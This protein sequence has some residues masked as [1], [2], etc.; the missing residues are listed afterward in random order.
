MISAPSRQRSRL[1]FAG[2]LSAVAGLLLLGACSLPDWA[3]P[4]SYFEPSYGPAP[5]PVARAGTD[6]LPASQPAPGLSSAT[7]N[8]QRSG[9]KPVIAVTQQS[10]TTPSSATPTTTVAAAGDRPEPARPVQVREVAQA[11]TVPAPR[12]RATAASA[13]PKKP[14]TPVVR[15]SAATRLAAVEQPAAEA[16]T[17]PA[18]APSPDPKP[19]A[20]R[21]RVRTGESP[22]PM[23][24]AMTQGQRPPSFTEDGGV[25][26][27]RTDVAANTN[28]GLDS[29]R[30]QSA[31]ISARQQPAQA[32][33]QPKPS[34]TYEEQL[35][36]AGINPVPTP[37]AA[38]QADGRVAPGPFPS[39]VAPVVVQT[40]QESLNAP[41]TYSEAIGGQPGSV[42]GSGTVVIGGNGVSQQTTVLTGAS[43]GPDAV[44]QFRHGSA[45][46]SSNDNAI[47]GRIAAQAA[48]RNAR[49]R[50]RG[51]SSSRTGQMPVDTHLLANLRISA[52]RAEAVADVLAR[53]GLPYERIIVEAKGDN[54]PVYNE[55]M[56][57]GE[58]GNRRAEIYLEN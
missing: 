52:R 6:P 41:R 27:R 11:T 40:Y 12:P 43:G 21:A 36:S 54:A 22:T 8:V 45:R 1:A 19:R 24:A 26:A 28:L 58:A 10:A 13:V 20:S 18:T 57:S 29:D 25:V 49:V 9:E 33:K 23:I 5:Q 37:S 53:F 48:Q 51:H 44:I 32:A 7:E 31:S 30:E 3:D 14:E 34:R 17:K 46:L 15:R 42:A 2:R 47:L 38:V 16:P 39:S 35:R 4:G 56:P 50:I 55:A